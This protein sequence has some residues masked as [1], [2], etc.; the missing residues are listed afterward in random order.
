[1]TP[2]AIGQNIAQA[3][4][5]KGLRQAELGGLLDVTQ[6]AVCAWERGRRQPSILRLAAIATHLD[7]TV[8]ALL[9]PAAA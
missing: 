5:H 9:T 1:M 6:S 4:H 8:D 3:R 7:T 2:I